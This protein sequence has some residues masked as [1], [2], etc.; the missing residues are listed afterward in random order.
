MKIRYRR[1][2]KARTSLSVSPQVHELVMHYAHKKNIMVED[3]TEYLIKH[4]IGKEL[5][6][7]ENGQN[8]T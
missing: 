2:L 8:S 6:D 5:L 1:K 4:S 3:A 7:I